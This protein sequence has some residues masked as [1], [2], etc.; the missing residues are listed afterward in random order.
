MLASPKP[1]ETHKRVAWAA[2]SFPGEKH[3]IYGIFFLGKLCMSSLRK[4]EADQKEN[5]N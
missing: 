1:E 4:E 2:V 5:G 3:Y